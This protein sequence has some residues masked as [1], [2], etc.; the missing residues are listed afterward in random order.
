MNANPVNGP[1]LRQV[2]CPYP[3]GCDEH[4]RFFCL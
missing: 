2:P 3:D 4:R 1:G